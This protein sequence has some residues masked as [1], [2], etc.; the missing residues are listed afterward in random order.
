MDD[1]DRIID[2]VYPEILDNK[3]LYLPREWIQFENKALRKTSK[4]IRKHGV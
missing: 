3:L 1:D 4:N 2:L